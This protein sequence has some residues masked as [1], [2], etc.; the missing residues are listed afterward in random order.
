LTANLT[1]KDSQTDSQSDGRRQT[2][3]LP[4]DKNPSNFNGRDTGGYRRTRLVL[5]RNQQVVR[6]TRIAGSSF[7]N[8]TPGSL[9]GRATPSFVVTAGS[10]RRQPLVIP[11]ENQMLRDRH[12]NLAA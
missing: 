11:F 8:K 7:P 5:F 10:Q 2:L 4:M 12:Q 3:H 1:A 9:P 6:S